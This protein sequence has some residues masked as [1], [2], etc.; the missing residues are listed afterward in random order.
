M[1]DYA[2]EIELL[3]LALSF[4]TEQRDSLQVQNSFLRKALEAEIDSH[5][6]TVMAFEQ[7]RNITEQKAPAVTNGDN[8]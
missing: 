4:V 2:E 7:Y 8:Q 6:G 3:Q 5:G 1:D